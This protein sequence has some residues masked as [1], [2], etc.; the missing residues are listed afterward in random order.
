MRQIAVLTVGRSDFGRYLPV[1]RSLDK[2]K[3]VKL[4]LIA[5]GA[6]FSS[7]FGNTISE[8]KDSGLRWEPGYHEALASDEP[9]NVGLAIGRGT[10][11]LTNLFA[12]NR[13]DLVVVLGDRF[14]ML[15]GANAAMGFNIP[16]VHIHGGAVTEGA[17]DELTRH[18]L[19]KMSHVHMVSCEP[20]AQRVRQ[21]G[22]EDWRIHV[23]GAPG[24]DNLLDIGS[25]AVDSLSAEVELDISRPSILACYH[26]VTVE[27]GQAGSQVA[28]ML[29][30]IE[31][32]GLQ[33]I[34]TYPNIDPGHRPIVEAI[35]EFASRDPKHR[36]LLKNAGHEIFS[37][38]LRNVDALIG[39]SSSGIVEAASFK[40]P[41]VN[42][43]TRQDGKV[44]AKNVI[45]VNYNLDDIES[46]LSQALSF[47]FKNSLS[48]LINPYGDGNAGPRIANIIASQAL[49]ARLLR[50]KFVKR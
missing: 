31:T 27:P 8:I 21:M 13:P 9:K 17:I 23:T 29:S 11:Y 43:G 6:H 39:N 24:L 47:K 18:A 14:E 28:N 32:I 16:V 35:E 20:Y 22:E 15:S 7:E 19:T 36:V 30:A 1:L 45:D 49:D 38:L 33:V 4:R 48:D 3:D 25:M 41:V 2:K 40:L 50:K 44:R 26:P 34:L 10:A 37:S 12:N 46:G 42:I 5:S